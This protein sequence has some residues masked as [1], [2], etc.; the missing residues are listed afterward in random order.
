MHRALST[1]LVALIA[2]GI[3]AYP[4]AS[5]AATV[6]PVPHL[7]YESACPATPIHCNAEVVISPRPA[8]SAPYGPATLRTAYNLPAAA[9][10]PQTVAIVDAGGDATIRSDLAAYD[11]RYGLPAA[12]LQIVNEQ[13]GTSLPASQGWEMEIAL[14]VETIHGLCPN[15]AI[16]L[17]EA[18][19][20]DSQNLATAENTAVR[21]GATEVSNSYGGDETS[22]L[23]AAYTHPGVAITASTGDSGYG[24]Q[25][26]ASIP[27]VIAVGGT[28]L[29]TETG[30]GYV[31]ER[32][33]SGAGSGCSGF[34]PEPAGRPATPCGSYRAEADVSS[35]ADPNTGVAIVSGGSWEQVGGTSLAS[36]TVAAE[37]A[38]A[39]GV[40]GVSDPARL[41]YAHQGDFRD[42][43]SGN[44]GSCASALCNA[45]PGWDG[46]TGLG[47]P[48]GVAGFQSSSSPAPT[49]TATSTPIVPTPSPTVTPP[50]PTPTPR[51]TPPAPRGFHGKHYE[52]FRVHHGLP[53]VPFLDHHGHLK[54]TAWAWQHDHFGGHSLEY[55]CGGVY[56]PAWWVGS[57][58]IQVFQGCVL[59]SGHD[60]GL[61]FARLKH[62]HS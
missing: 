7:A 44:N 8:D 49:P 36:P 42:V 60:A 1:L 30:G 18:A 55:W 6:R 61:S 39:G 50:N 56:A 54:K 47:S 57:L 2:L 17:V 46:P 19:A 9:P 58:R 35:D 21:L 59:Y 4:H 51:P 20:A 34:E 3:L 37:I 16:L 48:N 41:P 31:A 52:H 28:T 53:P 12:T 26:P 43:T 11:A 10:V 24:I 33:W 62:W 13:G 40:A 14:D 22:G 45:G 32:A 27:S 23:D 15:C 25:W 5:A 29:Y 38:L